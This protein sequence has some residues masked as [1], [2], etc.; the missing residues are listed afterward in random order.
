MDD[1]FQHGLRWQRERYGRTLFGEALFHLQVVFPVYALMGVD[2]ALVGGKGV[3]PESAAD[4][5]GLD[6]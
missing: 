4:W 5:A 1:L 3:F 2:I 6:E